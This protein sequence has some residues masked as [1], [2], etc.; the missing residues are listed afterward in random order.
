MGTDLPQPDTRPDPAAGAAL[1]LGVAAVL[2]AAVGVWVALGLGGNPGQGV[3]EAGLV[4]LAGAAGAAWAARRFRPARIRPAVEAADRQAREAAEQ[5]EA[6]VATLL[7]ASPD[8]LLVVSAREPDDLTG[9]RIERANAAARN[10]FRLVAPPAL[11]VS[12]LRD[13]EVLS[14]VDE[15]LFGGVEAA[16][17]FTSGAAQ[18]RTFQVLVRPLPPEA[19]G[20][21]RAVLLFRD[22]TD[23]RRAERTR[24][25][26]LA[27]AS[28]ELRTPLASLSGFIETLR[29]HA[30]DDRE[31]QDRFLAIMQN[32][33]DRM[34]RL[35]DDLLSLSRIELNEHVAPQGRTDL[36]LAAAD[37]V[38]ALGPQAA[39]RGVRIEA[40]L[41][42]PGEA[43]LCGDRDQLVQVIQNLTDNAVKYAPEGGVVRL[44]VRGPAERET[45]LAPHLADAARLTLV[46]PDSARGQYAMVRI[47]DEGPGLAR[48]HLPRLAER[49]YRV[50][51]QKSGERPGTGLGLSIVKHIVNRHQGVL[52]VES[53]QGRGTVFTVL[54]PS[55]LPVTE[56][57]Q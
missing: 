16:C 35:I 29:G 24:A 42:A 37:V 36:A 38:D 8:P 54:I 56:V 41:A 6:R 9:L 33:A 34:G 12:V 13:P 3:P 53:A 28:H 17:V 2:M 32:Q 10:L 7:D 23:L 57:S 47:Q 19:D 21:R 30:R 39:R 18:E 45:A 26:F 25:D 22:E 31:A 49:F 52:A 51:G 4:L 44:T 14:A 55:G 48:E 1:A 11:L 5:A 40:D 15:A 46:S 20:R 50:E 27:N 43:E